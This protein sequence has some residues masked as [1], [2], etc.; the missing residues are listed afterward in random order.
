MKSVWT[1]HPLDE[2]TLHL[3]HHITFP[4][5]L[6]VARINRRP[7][8]RELHPELQYFGST[9]ERFK[10]ATCRVKARR[11]PRRV[12]R[13]QRSVGRHKEMIRLRRWEKTPCCRPAVRM[14][15]CDFNCLGGGILSYLARKIFED[16]GPGL[17]TTSAA[18]VK[19]RVLC[20]D[21][22]AVIASQLPGPGQY[23][24]PRHQNKVRISVGSERG[25]SGCL[26]FS[27]LVS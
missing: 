7:N 11:P 18:N 10:E 14:W 17:P 26:C 27:L 13:H 12:P 20:Q 15:V 2:P 1:F 22:A 4:R 21:E 8:M 25:V 16:S 6:P 24:V 3:S 19:T 9:A 23:G 5:Q